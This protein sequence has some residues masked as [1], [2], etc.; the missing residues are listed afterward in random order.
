M[1]TSKWQ[2]NTYKW[3]QAASPR[4]VYADTFYR[5]AKD[6]VFA[7]LTEAT[8]ANQ[9]QAAQE[10]LLL[11]RQELET[12]M[13]PMHFASLIGRHLCVKDVY[14]EAI[15]RLRSLALLQPEPAP[16]PPEEKEDP[17]P[18]LTHEDVE[19]QFQSLPPDTFFGQEQDEDD[20]Q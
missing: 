13:P 16:P 9:F 11:L 17:Q 18:P 3:D 5:T 4:C 2:E 6:A 1:S 10:S 20:T 19:R 14:R 15:A 7:K 12:D 8:T